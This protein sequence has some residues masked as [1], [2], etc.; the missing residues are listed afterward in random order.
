MNS[1]ELDQGVRNKDSDILLGHPE[2]NTNEVG[3]LASGY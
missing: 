3:Q 1:H 2:L